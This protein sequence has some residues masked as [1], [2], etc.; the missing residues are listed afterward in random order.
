MDAE[1]EFLLYEKIN[2]KYSPCKFPKL[3]H[4]KD[5]TLDM[6]YSENTRLFATEYKEYMLIENRKYNNIH[7][8]EIIDYREE[9]L[10][11]SEI[12]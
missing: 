7:D 6:R 1:K 5:G 3:K 12:I 10:K 11:C 4:K 9:L 8:G 2:R